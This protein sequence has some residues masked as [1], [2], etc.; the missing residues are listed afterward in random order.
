MF[1][2]KHVF[3]LIVLISYSFCHAGSYDDFFTAIKHNDTNT[4]IGLLNRGFDAN[5][6]DPAGEHGLLLAIR[7]PSLEVTTVLIN[8]PKTK[9]ETRNSQDESPLMLAAINGFT[10]ICQQLISKG[11]DVNKPGWT[12]LHYAATHGHLA[13]MNLLLENYAY[14]DAASPN[15]STPLMMAASYGTP[16]AVKLLLEAGAD[17]ML[18]NDQGLSAIDF[19]QRANRAESAEIISAFVRGRQPKEKW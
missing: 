11:A 17:P 3:Y 10:E 2:F 12:P 15:G 16:M 7:E 18:K 8:W 4:V 19:A 5:T 14:I 13:V 9:V 1:N 6:L